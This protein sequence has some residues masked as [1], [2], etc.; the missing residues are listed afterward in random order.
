[1]L[2]NNLGGNIL[3][4]LQCWTELWEEGF[5]RNHQH[6]SMLEAVNRQL[7][8]DIAPKQVLF[9]PHIHCLEI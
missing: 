4:F 8:P 5:S 1:M 2:L 6:G 9:G 3:Q 7:V